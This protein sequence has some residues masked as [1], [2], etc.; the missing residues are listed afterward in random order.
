[1]NTTSENRSPSNETS[2]NFA[3]IDLGKETPEFALK[4]VHATQTFR[5]D[6][7]GIQ[8][9]VK[10]LKTIAHLGAIVMEAT[11]RLEHDAAIA[12][13][14]A[15]L[16]VM[17]IDPRQA[18]R[19]GEAAGDLSK[20][21]AIDARCLAMQAHYPYHTDKREGLFMRLPTQ[22]LGNP[23]GLGDAAR[24]AGRDPGGRTASTG[25]RAQAG[26]AQHR[27]RHQAVELADRRDR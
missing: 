20:T 1:M 27:I 9:L 7:K 12:L 19:F 3:G 13:C 6:P 25:G 16:P 8:A 21:G 10:H 18:R 4:G 24:P 5:N 15:G 2:L 22:E 17:V 14:A 23:V 11:G 26:S